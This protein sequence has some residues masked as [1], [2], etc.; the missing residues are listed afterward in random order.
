MLLEF[1]SVPPAI[2]VA[3]DLHRRIA[4]YNIAKDVSLALLLRVGV[5]SADVVVD[6][7][8]VY[9]AGVNLA[10][11]LASLA[12]PGETVVSAEVRDALVPGLHAEL[13]DLG[14]CYLKHLAQ[15]CRAFRVGPAGAVRVLPVEPM[16][17][18]TP[19]HSIAVVPLQGRGGES[20]SAIYGELIADGVIA[21][22]SRNRGLRVISRLSTTLLKGLDNLGDAVRSHLGATY[23][24][25]G[26]CLAHGDQLLV[27]VELADT[28]TET[29]I[30]AE[31]LRGPANDL[32]SEESSL[33]ND[34]AMGAHMAMLNTEVQRIQTQ[35]YPSLDSF[36]LLMG[37]ISLLHRSSAADFQ[38]AHEALT[39]L[40]ERTPRQASPYAWKAMWH[41]L[42]LIRGMS[43][44]PAEDRQR[45]RQDVERALDN[46][47]SS[48][49]ALT[50]KGLVVGFLDRD[51]D[52]AER[53]YEQALAINPNEPLA[54][55]FTCTLRSWQGRGAESAAAGERALQLSPLDPLRYY[56]DSLAAAGML[57]DHRYAR[58]IEL[59]QRSLRANRLHTATH[60]VLTIAQVLAGDE[61]AARQT[62]KVLLELEPQFTVSAYS[63]RYPGH[64][65]PH[66]ADY[67]QALRAA[68]IPQG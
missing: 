49:L 63:A 40:V 29:V 3:L 51:L 68:G 2:G 37:S 4:A 6:E 57:A 7:L 12:G 13:E 23:V 24:L 65:A 34:V 26:S 47:A 61:A 16:A 43:P 14:D 5:H 31:R 66:A 38:R 33:V 18:M 28:R 11:R 30:W 55:L 8:D 41:F 46:D 53:L 35:P 64:A 22:L 44:S 27:M 21:L 42:R 17:A 48:A 19:E 39:A 59:C 67:A 36:S 54:W 15:P 56:Y 62:A 20:M 50:L 58:A 60:R 32:F 10:A 25:S 45:A 1:A 52:Q 9:G